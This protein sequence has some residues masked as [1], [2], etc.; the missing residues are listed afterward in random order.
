M[1]GMRSF[2]AMSPSM[3][4]VIPTTVNPR[5]PIP[6]EKKKATIVIEALEIM[7]YTLIHHKMIH[8]STTT[9]Y[10]ERRMKRGRVIIKG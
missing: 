1:R 4:Q 6:K 7:W 10:R 3:I 8:A 9:A 2:Q 5:N